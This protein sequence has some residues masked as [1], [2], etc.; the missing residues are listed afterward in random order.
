MPAPV[1]VPDDAGDDHLFVV[2]RGGLPFAILEALKTPKATAWVDDGDALEA[3]RDTAANVVSEL[4]EHEVVPALEDDLRRR[5]VNLRRAVRSG[6]V[7]SAETEST[8]ELIGRFPVL[9]SG[10]AELTRAAEVVDRH[11]AG[12]AAVLGLDLEGVGLT[13]EDLVVNPSLRAGIVLQSRALDEFLDSYRKD[14][15]AGRAKRQR[16]LE[17]S[18]LNYVY[19]AAAK[20]SPFSSLGIVGVGRVADQDESG[21]DPGF[22][23]TR[24]QRPVASSRLNLAVIGRVIEAINASDDLLSDVPLALNSSLQTNKTRMR[25]I[26]RMRRASATGS[27]MDMGGVTESVFFLGVEHVMEELFTVFAD[28]H[29]TSPRAADRLVDH[30]GD[31]FTRD[32]IAGYLHTLQRVGFLTT[33]SLTIDIHS[34]RPV[35]RFVES[36]RGLGTDWAVIAAAL[37]DRAEHDA[38]GYAD[39]TLDVRRDTSTRIRDTLGELEGVLSAEDR[40]TTLDAIVF[41]DVADSGAEAVASVS[42]SF[43]ERDLRPVLTDYADVL[44]LYDPA[45]PSRLSMAAYFRA[46][47][48][49]DGVEPDVTTFLHEF[50]QDCFDQLQQAM[51]GHRDFDAEFAFHPLPNWFKLPEFDAIDQAKLRIREHLQDQ[52]RAAGPDARSVE[53]SP[54]WLHGIATAVPTV[55]QGI[56][57]RSFFLQIAAGAGGDGSPTAVVNKSYCGLGLHFSRFARLLEEGSGAGVVDHV[58]R[59]NQAPPE[60]AVVY[61]ELR[62]GFDTTN[63]NLHPY[64]TEYELVCP[65]EVSF[66]DPAEQIALESLSIRS[67]PDASGIYLWSETL[68]ARVV[69]VYLGFLLPFAL[70]ELQRELLLFSYTNMA[71]PELWTGVDFGEDGHRPRLVCGPAVLRRES[72]F[73]SMDE[74]PLSASSVDA[75]TRYRAWRQW[76]RSRGLPDQVFLQPRSGRVAPDPDAQAAEAFA[77][78]PLYVDF[79]SEPSLRL[80]EHAVRQ[81]REEIELVEMLPSPAGLWPDSG[82]G[83]AFVT[84]ITIDINA[85]GEVLRAEGRS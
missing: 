15:Q 26:R 29:L 68:G 36:L 1:T 71:M 33:P 27:P 30:L 85:P 10:L 64:L 2:R 77:A 48:G 51:L 55:E 69:P 19:R 24:S 22:A 43:W 50:G 84:E 79:E 80:F 53:L 76:Q 8:A 14:G 42:G 60:A 28:G 65:G 13:L 34:D 72:W 59:R 35:G 54:Q 21:V 17:R 74:L 75:A 63:L 38:A 44:A 4:L 25:Y 9:G 23:F 62:G 7:P 37:L 73:I 31:R 18:L 46:R 16:R 49:V 52:I 57:P 41:E 12:G 20:T 45:I 3:E 70:P 39:G 61:A 66:R 81:Q 6:K 5:A 40:I 82:T 67:W 83:E 32:E 47:H 11:W 56:N 58:R 78:K